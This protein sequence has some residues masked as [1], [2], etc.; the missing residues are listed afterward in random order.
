MILSF[1]LLG[2]AVSLGFMVLT[3][4]CIPETLN[5]CASFTGARFRPGHDCDEVSKINLSEVG[6]PTLNEAPSL[7]LKSRTE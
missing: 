4:L 5:V 6:R 3:W 7:G 1:L 2:S